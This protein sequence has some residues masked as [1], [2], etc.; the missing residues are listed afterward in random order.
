MS[1]PDWLPLMLCVW[2][3]AATSARA[4]LLPPLPPPLPAAGLRA[5][6]DSCGRAGPNPPA[7]V[8]RDRTLAGDRGAR[9]AAGAWSLAALVGQ[10][11]GIPGRALALIDGIA[12]DIP[13]TAIAVLASNPLVRR[14]ALDRLIAGADDYDQCDHRS[15]GG[16]RAIRLSTA[17]ASASRSSIPASRLARR[18]D[19]GSGVARSQRVDQFVD[20][21]NGQRSA[22]RRL[23]PRH[24][25][26]RHHRRQ[27]LR[28]G[29]R[30]R[31]HRARRRTWSC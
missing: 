1:R 12:A 19:A 11:G 28:L 18:S 16:A 21:V 5:A 26:R 2:L 9:T 24:A 22:V 3:L 4:Q 13:N 20:F 17:P 10:A 8:E 14:L 7:S 31:R 27:W 23:R 6:S 15:D 25:R 30:A 29:R